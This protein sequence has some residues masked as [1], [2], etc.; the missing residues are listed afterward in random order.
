[1][2]ERHPISRLVIDHQ[3]ESLAVQERAASK[4]E[5]VAGVWLGIIAQLIESGASRRDIIDAGGVLLAS[6]V[7]RATLLDELSEAAAL[8]EDQAR[9]TIETAL[10]TP[11]ELRRSFPTVTSRA[12]RARQEALAAA[13]RQVSS[14]VAGQ[15]ADNDRT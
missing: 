2:P 8:G 4:G 3:I 10:R 1:V 6:E 15:G 13:S 5:Q 9:E 7:I 12:L 11:A 14:E